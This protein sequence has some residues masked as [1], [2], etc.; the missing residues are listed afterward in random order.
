MN[1]ARIAPIAGPS[2]LSARYAGVIPG[3]MSL[4]V[5]NAVIMSVEIPMVNEGLKSRGKR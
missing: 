5:A 2:L 3:G 1:M 4:R